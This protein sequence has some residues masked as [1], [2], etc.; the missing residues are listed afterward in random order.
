MTEPTPELLTAARSKLRALDMTPVGLDATKLD[1]A[2]LDDLTRAVVTA[3]AEAD[4]STVAPAPPA[5]TFVPD[6]I[7][8]CPRCG[9]YRGR[10]TIRDVEPGTPPACFVCVTPTR[11][12][13]DA[14]E[15]LTREANLDDPPAVSDPEPAPAPDVVEIPEPAP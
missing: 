8:R 2:F 7:A 13:R 5:S 12:E 11:A 1:D 9:A 4:R 10:E 14:A 15:E 3:D 6:G